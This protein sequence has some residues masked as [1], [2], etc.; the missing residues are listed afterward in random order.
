MR[1][2][3]YGDEKMIFEVRGLKTDKYKGV[4]VGNIW[5]GTEGYVVCPNYAG[6]IAYDKDG[7]E[8]A[9][10]GWGKDSKGKEGNRLDQH[11]FDNFVKAVRSRKHEDLNSDIVRRPP[12]RVAVPPRQHQLPARHR[13]ADRQVGDRQQRQ[14]R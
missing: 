13:G 5:V 12:V 2:F 14:D 4:G 7:K 6:G 11:H 1:L 8:I 9:R 10:F 3:D